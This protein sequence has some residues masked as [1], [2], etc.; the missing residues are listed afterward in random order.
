M[1]IFQI[2][3]TDEKLS[4]VLLLLLHSKINHK[5]SFVLFWASVAVS[6]QDPESIDKL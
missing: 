1:H 4:V 6:F 5:K 2:N 3:T